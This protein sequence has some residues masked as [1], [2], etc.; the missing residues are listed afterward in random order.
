MNMRSVA[1]LVV[2]LV[3]AGFTA[4]FARSWI[5]AER[6]AILASVPEQ[7]EEL[8]ATQ[9]LIAKEELHAGSFVR[10]KNLKWQT[11]PEDGLTEEYV[12]K[13]KRTITDFEGAVVR[14]AISVGQPITDSLVVHPGDRGFLAAVLTPGMRAVSVPV[15]ATS[16][17]S[18]FVFPGDWVDVV[19]TMRVN[20]E[21]N[22]TGK[23][24]TK[25]RHFS[26]TLLTNVR[27][28]AIDQKTENQEGQ[29]TVAKTATLEVS[30]KQAEK[31]ALGLELG[32][33]SLSLLS[34]AREEGDFALLA[35]NAMPDQ[36]KDKKDGVEK[37][38][39]ER[40]YTMDREITYPQVLLGSRKQEINVLR[41]G[42]DAEVATF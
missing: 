39:N 40:S 13:G 5:L 22:E 30:P 19:L 28:L 15:N 16:G 7:T 12:V 2:A 31:I 25:A 14:R 33:L 23:A 42:K 9:V 10:P 26:E 29:A 36:K 11:W 3:V 8:P 18:G 32:N 27:V 17:I 1:L 37:A 20:V 21:D 24:G 41:G 34:L 6:A 38:K 4:F 35:R